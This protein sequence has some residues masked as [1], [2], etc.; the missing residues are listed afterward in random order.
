MADRLAGG[1]LGTRM[2]ES[3]PDEVG[4]LERSFNVMADSLEKGRDELA[5]S[6]AR[7]VAAADETRRQIE[8]DL[9]DGAQQRLV[10]L[11]LELR[12]AQAATPPGA[13]LEGQLAR[14]AEGL[15]PWTSRFHSANERG[16]R[17]TL[18]PAPR[19]RCSG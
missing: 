9:H 8:R 5:A 3:G 2:I 10:S 7:I 14:V 19:H 18:G 12:A 11:A 17:S 6:R 4:T 1:D 13:E 16:R 15:A